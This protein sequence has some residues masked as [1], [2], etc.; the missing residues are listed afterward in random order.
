MKLST[1]AVFLLIVT[2][3]IVIF[4]NTGSLSP[5]SANLNF[6]NQSED[7]D[8]GT[9]KVWNFFTNPT[10]WTSSGGLVYYLIILLAGTLTTFIVAAIVTKAYAPDTYLFATYFGI[11][12]GFGSIPV[13]LLY[14]FTQRE[15]SSYMCTTGTF[16][17]FPTVVAMVVAGGLGFMWIMKC[18]ESWRTGID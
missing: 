9:V 14:N 17:L 2:L 6:Y 12:A 11:L 10:D 16:C 1:M 4:D 7:T 8:S 15:L 3:V 18:I 5:E 13:T